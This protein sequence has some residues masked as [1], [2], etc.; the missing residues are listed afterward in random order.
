MTICERNIFAQFANHYRRRLETINLIITSFVN[1]KMI[2]IKI[3]RFNWPFVLHNNDDD[4]IGWLSIYTL[5]NVKTKISI[6]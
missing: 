1:I 4:L 5:V 3:F 2:E 6:K